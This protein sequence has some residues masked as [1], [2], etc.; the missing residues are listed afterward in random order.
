MDEF[1]AL[2]TTATIQNPQWGIRYS[3]DFFL[4]QEP[5]LATFSSQNP[6]L[7]ARPVAQ[8]GRQAAWYVSLPRA[9]SGVLRHY[10]RGGLVAR[11]FHDQYLWCGAKRTRSWSEFEVMIYLHHHGVAVPMPVAALWQRHGIYYRAAL[12][13]EHVVGARPLAQ[14]LSEALIRPV[15]QAIKSMHDAGVYHADLNV[16]NI[17]LDAQEQVWL[18]DF[19][20]A[21]RFNTLS[22][23]RRNQNLVRLQR[24]LIKEFGPA[25]QRWYEQL[26]Q[27]YRQWMLGS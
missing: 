11:F 1:T 13:T 26:S 22:F 14:A 18:I 12:I 17:L 21:K 2:P 19:D 24:S 7:A 16:F 10:R 3:V 8:G 20:R 6:V 27:I 5:G 9:Q 25:G 4:G 23:T 15:A